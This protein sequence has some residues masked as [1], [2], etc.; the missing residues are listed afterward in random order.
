MADLPEALK[1][2][3]PAPFLL[4][5]TVAWW[6]GGDSLKDLFQEEIAHPPAHIQ[7]EDD[8]DHLHRVVIEI[9]PHSPKAFEAV[10]IEVDLVAKPDDITAQRAALDGSHLKLDI[11]PKDNSQDQFFA[12][13]LVGQSAPITLEQRETI[14]ISLHETAGKAVREVWLHSKDR[15]PIAASALNQRWPLTDSVWRIV[16][17]LLGLLALYYLIKFVVSLFSKKA[18]RQL[19]EDVDFLHNCLNGDA[20]SVSR[21]DRDLQP[22]I[23]AGTTK[24]LRAFTDAVREPARQTLIRHEIF[25][26][27]DT[28]PQI[29]KSLS[30][31]VQRFVITFCVGMLKRE[32]ET[33]QKIGKTD[34]AKIH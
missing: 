31:E 15:A 33:I 13:R 10:S 24:Y 17:G 14:E 28:L 11:R 20:T 34:A 8:R 29:R 12:D 16:L 27:A 19:D 2:Y 32:Y 1:Q 4:A 5:L 9:T 25:R 21:F 18:Q 7:I 26:R 22:L 30:G 3:L 6:M 23:D